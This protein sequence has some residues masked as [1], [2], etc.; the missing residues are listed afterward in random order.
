M[1]KLT[2]LYTYEEIHRIENSL[3]LDFQLP[4]N[5]VKAKGYYMD[6]YNN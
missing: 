6:L 1:D 2:K 5:S 3:L 4:Y